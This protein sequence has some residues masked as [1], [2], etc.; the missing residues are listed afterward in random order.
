[1]SDLMEKIWKELHSG[2]DR[3]LDGVVDELGYYLDERLDYRPKNKKG[4]VAWMEQV[5]GNIKEFSSDR[6]IDLAMMVL[7]RLVAAQISPEDPAS[8][9]SKCSRHFQR[10]P[11]KREDNRIPGHCVQ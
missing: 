9:P 1:M 4:F 2:Q 3:T 11:S 5:V 7:K 10:S 6:L 8:T